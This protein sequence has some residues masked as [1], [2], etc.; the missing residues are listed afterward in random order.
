MRC[1]FTS[2]VRVPLPILVLCV[3]SI[4]A[5][6]R[7]TESP[8]KS[9][10][11]AS[12]EDA[13]ATTKES[14]STGSESV[15][16]APLQTPVELEWVQGALSE[17]VV[18]TGKELGNLY[19]PETT[20]GGIAAFD[21]DRDGWSDLV[22]AGG[23]KADEARRLMVGSSGA[24]YRNRTVNDEQV[25]F[26][27][28]REQSKLDFTHQ[29]NTG[30]A[31]ADV[32]ADGFQDVF[33]AGYSMGQLFRN[34]GD[35]TF[36]WME[37]KQVGLGSTLW[38]A[39]AAFFDMDSDGLVDLYVANYA[40]WSFDNNPVCGN[41]ARS[42]G[43]SKSSDYCGPREF[44]GLPDVL[45][46]NGGDGTF[47]DRTKDA[48]MEDSL[49][50]LGVVAAD[51]DL[52]GDIDLY[53]ANDVDPNL[54]YRNDGGGKFTE[55]GRR[56][57]VATNDAGTPEGSMG[58]SVGDFNMDGKPDL[59]VT[60]YQNELGALYRNSGN[61]VFNYASLTARIA[62]TDEASVGWG[63]AF[64]D[65][66]GDGD[67]D[68][69]VLNGHIELHP[70][71]ST[72]DQRPQVLL[73]QGG[74]SFLLAPRGAS[75]FLQEPQNARGLAMADWN[76][77]GKMDFAASR[78]DREA[79]LVLNRTGKQRS[80]RLRLVGTASNRDAIG[81]RVK[82]KVGSYEA[83]RQAVGGGSYA[84]SH[85]GLL[86]IAVPAEHWVSGQR[87]SAELVIDWPNGKRDEHVLEDWDREWI[88]V[89]GERLP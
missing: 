27:S 22:C 67:E 26:A 14:E 42:G 58:L 61:L 85:E 18:R 47:E 16:N 56:A 71:G 17:A 13:G 23:G 32:D 77:D 70:R 80:V 49:R 48:G 76:R 35:G 34:Q 40:N 65:V 69:L 75:P 29:Y 45:Y 50:G 39:S 57:G 66:D 53:V 20:G 10:G 72:V 59:W 24:L 83:T 36:E 7:G 73:N 15:V 51:W 52:D 41:E 3:I 46:R 30:I 44:Q 4:F 11:G 28:V 60:N 55:I 74:K 6:C 79:A 19:L 1:F 84:S 78:V 9:S 68:L 2:T 81:A 87:E 89:E 33:I 38:G 82:L 5:G 21:F 86:H 62:A 88:V 8:E 63:T 12:A 31:I 64:C 54:L 43:G 25:S 37:G